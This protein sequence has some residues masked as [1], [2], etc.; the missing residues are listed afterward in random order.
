MSTDL[1][2][3]DDIQPIQ[4][5]TLSYSHDDD[6]F[7]ERNAIRVIEAVT[8]QSKL[9]RLYREGIRLV[10]EG[11]PFWNAG[12]ELL[13]V[14]YE[15]AGEQWSDPDPSRPLVV[16][17]NHPFGVIDGLLLC[18]LVSE[19]RRDFRLLVNEVFCRHPAFAPYLVPIDFRGT[20]E[21]IRNNVESR[22]TALNKLK[23]G[24][25]VI[26][27]PGGGVATR[28]RIG[29]PLKELPW[30]NFTAKIIQ[31]S[32]ANILPLFFHGE[33]SWLFHAASRM[34]MTVRLALF[35]Y[36]TRRMLGSH[37]KLTVR[38]QIRH[39]ELLDFESRN[40]LMQFLHDR[41]VLDSSCQIPG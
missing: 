14:T 7:F 25:P 19:L 34:S 37:I 17:A 33:N 23:E 13:K 39:E 38:K 24:F 10:E 30:G 29:G 18:K 12:L 28:N 6:P 21:A 15:V 11:V 2:L 4:E 27:F 16:I 9:L 3:E 26:I 5:V 41:T 40:D 32:Q 36:E 31:Q 1:A 20:S 8:G 22:R 35:L